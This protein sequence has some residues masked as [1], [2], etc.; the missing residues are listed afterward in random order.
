MLLK[1]V[2]RASATL[3]QN[4]RFVVTFTP[5]QFDGLLLELNLRKLMR[6]KTR[7][8]KT[9]RVIKQINVS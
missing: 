7:Q 8:V 3:I 6:F 9:S 1:I 5:T 2:P 4:P